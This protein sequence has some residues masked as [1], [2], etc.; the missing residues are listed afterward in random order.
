MDSA[1]LINKVTRCDS[2]RLIGSEALTAGEL[3]RHELRTSYAVYI[4]TSTRRSERS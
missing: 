4:P 2:D 3:T 1:G